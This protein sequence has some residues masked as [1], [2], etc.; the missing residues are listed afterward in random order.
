MLT[1]YH[2][3][4]E[5]TQQQIALVKDYHTAWKGVQQD[6]HFTTD[7]VRYIGQ[8]YTGIINAS[9]KNLDEV[10]L[11]INSFITQMTDAKRL[12][13]INHAAGAMQTNLDDPE[14]I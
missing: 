4:K 3:I 5:I 10:A 13:I 8:V 7:E 1:Y 12:E 14:V 2:R 6:G 11:V 9:L